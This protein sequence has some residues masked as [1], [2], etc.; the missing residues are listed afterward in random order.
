MAEEHIPAAAQFESMSET[1]P[2][3]DPSGDD[4]LRNV[5]KRGAT[6]E[7]IAREQHV[8]EA[9]A[10]PNPVPGTKAPPPAG[11][12][13]ILWHS[14]APWVGSGYG[15]QSALFGPLIARDIGHDVAFSAF[16]GLKG[17]RLGWVDP[18][19]NL[20]FQVYPGSRDNHGNDILVAHSK[21]FF[22][23]RDGWVVFL[24]DPWVLRAELAREMNMIA[25]CPVDHDPVIPQTYHWFVASG[26]FP[27]AM[28]KWGQER[29]LETNIKP[30]AYVPHGFDPDTFKPA[31]RKEAREVLRLPKDAFIIGMVAA[32]LGIPGR[33]SF[34]QSLNAFKIFKE[35]HPDAEL[36][37]HTQ[38]EHPIGENLTA[39]CDSLGIRPYTADQYGLVLGAPATLVA[40]V[41]NAMDVLLNPSMGEGFGVPLIEA[42]AC[43]TPCIVNDFSA[44]P[45][46]APVEAGNWTTT[47]QPVWT[48]FN[49]WQQ[50]PDIESIVDC[51]EQAYADSEEERQARRV[52]VYKW[53]Q[54]E[55]RADVVL[56][57]HWRPA[58]KAAREEFLWNTKRLRRLDG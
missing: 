28:S 10:D 4:Y 41:H 53:A 38:M 24:S 21:H 6:R 14:N 52:S 58:L 2:G 8:Q 19:T 43:G 32:N 51:L 57:Q 47:G 45:E 50:T 44:M 25:W 54:Q 42:Q 3:H 34:V 12:E 1:P 17:R 13:P 48:G 39:I 37:L 46:V 36:Y 7:A 35:R 49:S 9:K 31:D 23:G 16:Y 15:T 56:D 20:P 33:K 30:V 55:Y 18:M 5:L 26:A 29:L 22:Q 27:L 40:A 11:L